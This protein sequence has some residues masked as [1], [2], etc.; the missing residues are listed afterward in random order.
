LARDQFPDGCFEPPPGVQNVITCI[1]IARN[2]DRPPERAV[3][4][5]TEYQILDTDTRAPRKEQ[6]KAVI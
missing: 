4:Y 1:R 2:G 6:A 5:P 3:H